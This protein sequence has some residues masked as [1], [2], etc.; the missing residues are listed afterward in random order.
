ME[1][2]NYNEISLCKGLYFFQRNG[3]TDRIKH[4]GMH[5]RS[6][7]GHSAWVALCAHPTHT[8]VDTHSIQES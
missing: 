8:D 2:S 7:S 5:S 4:M 6:E 1:P 3:T